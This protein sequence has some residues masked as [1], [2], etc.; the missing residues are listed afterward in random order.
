MSKY[1]EHVSYLSV[2]CVPA[3]VTLNLEIN[4]N[5]ASRFFDEMASREITS[6]KIHDSL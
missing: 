2:H 3:Y 1:L 6:V 4:F 5:F